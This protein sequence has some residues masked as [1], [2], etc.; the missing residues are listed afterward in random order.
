LGEAG[1]QAGDHGWSLGL[2]KDGMMAG[3]GA[4]CKRAG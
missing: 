3:K 2:S 4:G 1:A